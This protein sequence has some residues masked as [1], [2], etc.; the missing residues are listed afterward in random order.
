VSRLAFRFAIAA[1]AAVAC[2][3]PSPD[4]LE[5]VSRTAPIEGGL[6]APTVSLIEGDLLAVDVNSIDG[7]E[8][9]GLCVE[10]SS[11]SD[12]VEVGRVRGQC[13]LFFVMARAPGTARVRFEARGT[14]TELLVDVTR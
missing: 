9:M 6:G 1:A 13:R 11:S 3:P 8:E 5:L 2:G 12:A 4:R 14:R 7:D 10:A